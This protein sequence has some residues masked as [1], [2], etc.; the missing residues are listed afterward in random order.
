MFKF[1]AFV[2]WILQ[3]RR[4]EQRNRREEQRIR[5]E[6]QEHRRKAYVLRCERE[7][8]ETDEMRRSRENEYGENAVLE[9]ARAKYHK[10]EALFSKNR[11]MF[12]LSDEKHWN[13]EYSVY[14]DVSIAT[15]VHSVGYESIDAFWADHN[16]S[17]TKFCADFRM[18]HMLDKVDDFVET[19][20]IEHKAK[21]ISR[22]NALGSSV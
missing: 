5:R 7:T 19:M 15:I 18:Y 11:E 9:F 14:T 4:E 3:R 6:E 20:M 1:I 13:D 8:C 21:A 22:L 17:K 10:R 2:L 16:T 12:V